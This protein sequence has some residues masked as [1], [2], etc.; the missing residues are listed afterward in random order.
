[1]AT[2]SIKSSAVLEF[3]LRAIS[4]HLSALVE[5]QTRGAA[6]QHWQ[7]REITLVAEPNQALQADGEVLGETPVSAKVLPGVV[8]VIVPGD[9]RVLNAPTK[10]Q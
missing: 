1:M 10:G 5:L 8:G 3:L 6:L 2:R 4:W 9:A 7:G